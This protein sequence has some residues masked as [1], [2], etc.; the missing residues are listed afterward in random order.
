[1]GMV[2]AYE[3]SITMGTT[4]LS[5]FILFGFVVEHNMIKKVNRDYEIDDYT[6]RQSFIKLNFFMIATF[7]ILITTIFAIHQLYSLIMLSW[8]FLISLGYFAIGFILN[9]KLF[10]QMAQFNIISSFILIII[11]VYF[12]ILIGTDSLF[13][14]LTQAIN[15]FGLAVAP[16]WVARKQ[17]I[18]ENIGV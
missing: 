9:I 4:L 15:I 8:L 18:K 17:K 6:N 10:T 16:A 3:Y 5:F 1:M 11:G 14:T 12:D 13:L 7:A 2:S